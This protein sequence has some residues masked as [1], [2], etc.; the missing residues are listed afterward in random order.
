MSIVRV[1]QMQ[2]KFEDSELREYVKQ[3]IGAA[4][5]SVVR[6]EVAAL[7]HEEME[8]KLR[9]ITPHSIQVAMSG[10]LDERIKKTV[11][12]AFKVL[13]DSGVDSAYP[14]WN[15]PLLFIQKMV[16]GIREELKEKLWKYVSSKIGVDLTLSLKEK[17]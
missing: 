6:S 10:I 4:T 2:V 14:N 1:E 11:D 15:P 9:E 5:K 7:I 3:H 16:L 12:G 13:N 8:K 17:K